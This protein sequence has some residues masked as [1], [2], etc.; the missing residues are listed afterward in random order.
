MGNTFLPPVFTC[1]FLCPPDF[2]FSPFFHKS[3][4]FLSVFFPLWQTHTLPNMLP[5]SATLPAAIRFTVLVKHL[6]PQSRKLQKSALMTCDGPFNHSGSERDPSVRSCSTK[7]CTHTH[8]QGCVAVG[9]LWGRF[10]R[11]TGG[12]WSF[13]RAAPANCGWGQNTLKIT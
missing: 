6:V 7:T 5:F 8:T 1:F 13:Y 11:W 10:L 3:C 4:R 12:P 9:Q 2:Y